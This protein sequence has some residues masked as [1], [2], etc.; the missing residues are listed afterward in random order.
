MDRQRQLRL[1]PEEKEI[2]RDPAMPGERWQ[3][4]ENASP[5]EAE[6]P[7]LDEAERWVLAAYLRGEARKLGERAPGSITNAQ[8]S[9]LF[10]S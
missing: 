3:A 5:F 7:V 9:L 1:W 2:E 6:K 4:K 8:L 10:P